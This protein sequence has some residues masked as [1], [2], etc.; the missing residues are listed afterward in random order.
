MDKNFVE[1][2]AN[3]KDELAELQNQVHA[4]RERLKERKKLFE[5]SNP[6]REVV[7]FNTGQQFGELALLNDEPR[8]ATVISTK[9]THF[10]TIEKEGFVQLIQKYEKRQQ[11]QMVAF[12][13][14]F[15]YF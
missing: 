12:L 13:K 14:Q 7:R 11:E 2:T 6:L 4:V 3:Q 1:L 5:A 8:A 15:P 10:L 9:H